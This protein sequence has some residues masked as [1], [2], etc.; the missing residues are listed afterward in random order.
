MNPSD[1]GELFQAE[2]FK[3]VTSAGGQSFESV[4]ESV[5]AQKLKELNCGAV[6]GGNGAAGSEVS[7]VAASIV[8]TSMA[9]LGTLL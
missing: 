4:D 6:G 7:L 8:M 1:K 3:Y 9:L 2:E 5:C